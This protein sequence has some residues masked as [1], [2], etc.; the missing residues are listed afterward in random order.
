MTHHSLQA[1]RPLSKSTKPYKGLGMEGWIAKWY[2]KIR[3]QDPELEMVINQVSEVL[4]ADSQI[5]EVAPGPGSLAIELAKLGK[6]QVVGLDISKSFVEIAQGKAKEAGVVVEFCL[7][8]ASDMPLNAN[9]FDFI[10]CRAAFKNFSEPLQA[11]R[12][13]YRVLK[14][15]GKVLIVDLRRDVS[16][17]AINTYIHNMELNPINTLMTRWTF[18]HMLLKRAYTQSE[19]RQFVAQ[20]DFVTCEISEDL[21]GMEVWLEK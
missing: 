2:T 15:S 3:A 11:L 17:E 4:S 19:I 16:Q 12:E 13:M 18:S 7:G 1:A 6:Y 8:N 20:T 21:I 14:P 5:L 9:T 10:I